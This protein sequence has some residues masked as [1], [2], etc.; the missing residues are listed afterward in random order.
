[1]I[2][3][4]DIYQHIWKE[5]A[6]IRK[7]TTGEDEDVHDKVGG[8]IYSGFYGENVIYEYTEAAT[9]SVL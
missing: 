4:G 8:C 5:L 9:G 1:M 6:L 2:S 3:D 7:E